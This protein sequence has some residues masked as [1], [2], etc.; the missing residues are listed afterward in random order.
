MTRSSLLKPLAAVKPLSGPGSG[1]AL[2]ALTNP[3]STAP[4]QTERLLSCSSDLVPEHRRGIARTIARTRPGGGSRQTYNADLALLET[5][6]G[7][8]A[9][10]ATDSK[11]CRRGKRI[12]D[13]QVP[14]SA[15][16]VAP[17]EAFSVRC[18]VHRIL[19]WAHWPIRR[20]GGGYRLAAS[21]KLPN[22]QG[23]KL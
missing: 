22:Q 5:F 6:N 12:P 14:S 21:P 4:S 17:Y 3:G 18:A 23:G 2:A 10:V 7:A 20:F 15:S 9:G 8:G 13:F 11:T 1:S 16:L 19:P